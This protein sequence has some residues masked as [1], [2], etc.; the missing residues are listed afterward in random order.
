ML[1]GLRVEIN[2][3]F[4]F[5]TWEQAKY[6]AP[7]LCNKTIEWWTYINSLLTIMIRDEIFFV[8]DYLQIFKI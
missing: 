6:L 4:Q 8:I 3:Q 2:L 7:V 1:Q 5:A